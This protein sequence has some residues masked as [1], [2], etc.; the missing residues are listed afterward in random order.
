MF[1]REKKYL[2]SVR[3]GQEAIED[4]ERET[5]NEVINVSFYCCEEI[6]GTLFSVIIRKLYLERAM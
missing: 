3:S 4:G 2:I 6:N 1:K 5:G